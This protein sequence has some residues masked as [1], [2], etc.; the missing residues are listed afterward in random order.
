MLFDLSNDEMETKD[1]SL[2][3]PKIYKELKSLY[4]K[5]DKGLALP[6]WTDPHLQNVKKEEQN[7][8]TI[9]YNSLSKNERENYNL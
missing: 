1:I 6:K 2:E 8:Q 3:N 9:R 5:W 4:N 7:V